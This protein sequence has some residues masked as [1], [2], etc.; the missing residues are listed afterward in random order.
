M[1]HIIFIFLALGFCSCSSN[2]NKKTDTDSANAI[3]Q[4]PL[5][6]T[7]VSPNPNGYAPPNATVD[8]SQRVKDSINGAT[9]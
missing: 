3:E 9:H 7:M 8:T 6:D 2:T 5:M 4:H 1:K